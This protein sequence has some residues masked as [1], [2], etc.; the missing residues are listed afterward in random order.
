MSI[1][2]AKSRSLVLKEGKV[3]E[4]FRFNIKGMLIPTI[5]EMPVKSSGKVFDSSLKDYGNSIK[6][7]FP[8]KSLEEEFKILRTR[9]V[10]MCRDSRDPKV[11]QVGVVVRTGR[12]WNAWAAVLD[13]AGTPCCATKIWRTWWLM[14]ERAWDCSQ[15]L[16]TRSARGR[17][18]GGKFRRAAV[19]KERSSKVAG[20][21]Q[22]GAWTK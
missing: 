15:H 20:L 12:K 3:T 11:A 2:P 4:R 5:T 9:E 16:G 6:L 18:S 10:L 7:W 13:V 22:Q 21:R 17:R 1:K 8:L 14:V 19:E